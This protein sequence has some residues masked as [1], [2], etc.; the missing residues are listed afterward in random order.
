[1]YKITIE[2][3]EKL[4]KA[5]VDSNNHIKNRY[6]SGTETRERKVISQNEKAI[7]LIE[8][9]YLNIGK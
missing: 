4:R 2:H 6:K 3:L 7:S 9:E 5:L 1:M 8:N